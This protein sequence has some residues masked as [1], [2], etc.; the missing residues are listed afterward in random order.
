[1]EGFLLA[2]N[3]AARSKFHLQHFENRIYL[4]DRDYTLYGHM[5]V[6][7]NGP[8]VLQNQADGSQR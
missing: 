5:T 6:Q 4:L 3:E 2:E 8:P 1:M 7:V